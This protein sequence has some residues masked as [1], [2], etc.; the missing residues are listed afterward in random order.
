MPKEKIKNWLI[1]CCARRDP[2][3]GSLHL[4]HPISVTHSIPK[5]RRITGTTKTE[6]G[7]KRI[8][9]TR[10][11]EPKFTCCKD[12]YSQAMSWVSK[13]SSPSSTGRWSPTP[14]ISETPTR[15]SISLNYHQARS[16][17][18]LGMVNS[19]SLEDWPWPK[20]KKQRH[21]QN[22]LSSIKTPWP[23]CQMPVT[24][25][26]WCAQLFAPI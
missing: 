6:P 19:F 15:R 2:P 11:E 14:D 17:K 23:H 7:T 10:S 20:S 25:R 8:E 4:D 18:L 12:S 22:Q 5:P 13:P 24:L 1:T 21:C 9:T 26:S 16:C 3:T